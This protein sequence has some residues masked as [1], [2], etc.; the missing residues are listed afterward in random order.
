[1][2]ARYLHA[3]CVGILIFSSTCAQGRNNYE[4]AIEERLYA[5]HKLVRQER[6]EDAM[7]YVYP[8]L[9][10]LLSTDDLVEQLRY[11]SHHPDFFIT[12][13]DR[14][15]TSF[16][17]PMESEGNVYL[18]VHFQQTLYVNFRGDAGQ[19]RDFID[20]TIIMFSEEYGMDRVHH[21]PATDE[22]IIEVPKHF[23]AIRTDADLEWFFLD[24]DPTISPL[25]ASI[26]PQ[27]VFKHLK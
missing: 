11:N 9:F 1:M 3:I 10:Q 2:M 6:F 26:L 18:E 14:Q 25:L 7:R 4:L 17:P 19:D 27:N 16:G 15:A 22:L 12:L 23:L 8:P 20:A 24:V 5:Y 13:A 21:D